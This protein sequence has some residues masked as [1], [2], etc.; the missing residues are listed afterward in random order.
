[1]SK[2]TRPT[3]SSPRL[4]RRIFSRRPT[5]EQVGALRHNPRVLLYR[6]LSAAGLIFYSPYALVRALLGRRRLGD[7]RGRFGKTRY[8]DLGG[9]IWVHAVSVGEVG[10]ARTVISALARRAPAQKV[11]LS[12]TTEAGRQL[13]ETIA[14]H[15]FPI[16]AFPFDL[17]GPVEKALASVRPGLIL[18]TETEIWPLFLQRAAAHAIPVALIN[19]RVSVRSFRRYR[20][21]ARW[22]AERFSHMSLFAMQSNADAERIVAL[23]APES[24]VH[25]TG[26]L[27]YDTPEAPSFPDADRLRRAAAGRP[28]FV[29]ASTA[30]GEEQI[31]L[32]AWQS[33]G[34]RPL[35]ALAP[36]RPER[37]DSVAALIERAGFSVL[38]RS[39]AS[40]PESGIPNGA[41]R[42]R[43][44]DT[45]Y[46]LDSI[47]ELSSLYREAR[48]AFIGGS[49]VPL[50]GHN[51]IEA[52]AAGVPALAGPHTENFRQVM[53]D[54]ERLGFLRRVSDAASLAREVAPLL[55]VAGGVSASGERARRFVAE[56]RG[57]AERTVELLLP[58]LAPRAER[59]AVK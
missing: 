54:G 53:A 30:E 58:L 38:R 55:S 32:Q 42:T 25:V 19:G 45:V 5:G 41:S 20:L 6:L 49:L 57:A 8:P 31:V 12:V 24:R 39:S 18:L 26:N 23:G 27:K 9:G 28:I 44:P 15:A 47:G 43:G 52:W 11:G 10:V 46:L 34:P 51:P 1:V 13:A 7:V 36:R 48:A 4:D 14:G 2:A 17:A 40:N 21:V 56:N 29:A 59:R 33:L 16:F 37:F 50:G 3:P 35:L 22:L